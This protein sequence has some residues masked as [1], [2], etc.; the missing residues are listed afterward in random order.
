[1]AMSKII[2]ALPKHAVCTSS[3]IRIVKQKEKE[4]DKEWLGGEIG[5]MF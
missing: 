4:K 3:S 2:E 1:M 5:I